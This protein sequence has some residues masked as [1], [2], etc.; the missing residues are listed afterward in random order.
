MGHP[1]HPHLTSARLAQRLLS[2]LPPSHPSQLSSH[3]SLYP[4]DLYPQP[5]PHT[6]LP[7]WSSPYPFVAARLPPLPP[8]KLAWNDPRNIFLGSASTVSEPSWEEVEWDEDKDETRSPRVEMGA[9]TSLLA[10]LGLQTNPSLGLSIS[11]D[12]QQD[13]AGDEEVESAPALERGESH[14]RN[15]GGGATSEADL[16]DFFFSC[17]RASPPDISRSG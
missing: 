5:C 7:S 17:R 3:A 13:Q 4:R 1:P 10:R 8:P 15:K 9:S 11:R 16:V 2:N 14:R 12:E 6:L